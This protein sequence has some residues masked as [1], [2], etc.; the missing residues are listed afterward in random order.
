MVGVPVVTTYT[1][2]IPDNMCAPPKLNV[3]LWSDVPIIYYNFKKIILL[4]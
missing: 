3:I 1:L 2:D 4:I